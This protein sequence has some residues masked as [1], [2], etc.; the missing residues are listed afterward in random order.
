MQVLALRAHRAAHR[1]TVEVDHC[2]GCRL[3]WFDRIESVQLDGLGWIALLREMQAGTALP[4]ADAPAAPACPVCRSALRP[5][6]N[7][8]RFGRF[9]VLE[10]NR[11]DLPSHGHLHSHGGLLAERG[12]VRPL[13][14]PERKA[15]A[16]ERHRIECFNCGAP[17]E[18]DATD[19]RWCGSPLVVLDLPRLAHALRVQLQADEPTPVVAGRTV[20]WPCRSC[21]TA[22]NPNRD[23]QCPTCGHLVVVPSLGEIVPVLDAA[24]AD[25]EAAAGGLRLEPL[26]PPP[27]RAAPRARDPR[28]RATGLDLLRLGRGD[29]GLFDLRRGDGHVWR[30]LPTAVALLVAVLWWLLGG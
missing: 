22:L 20:A 7:Q 11:P 9:Q 30:W 12:L 19:C 23:T 21:G 24:Q 3:V 29:D 8:T 1:D 10:C 14:W 15:L 27:A 5:V 2:R 26:Q 16:Q 28:R 6:H 18:G 4:M 25:L 17:V 13:G